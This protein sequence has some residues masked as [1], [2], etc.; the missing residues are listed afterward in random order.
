MVTSLPRVALG[1]QPA[2]RR[3]PKDGTSTGISRPGLA[4]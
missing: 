4:V 1:Q 3:R 2:L